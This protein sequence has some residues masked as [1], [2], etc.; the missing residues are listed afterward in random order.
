MRL[1]KEKSSPVLTLLLLI[2]LIFVV[3]VVLP[4]YVNLHRRAKQMSTKSRLDALHRALEY[5]YAAHGDIYPA[6]L[7]DLAPHYVSEIP[8]VELG[9]MKYNETNETTDEMEDSGKW[10]YHRY[11]G[12]VIVDSFSKDCDGKIISTW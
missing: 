6:M 5:Y 3:G 12:E 10:Y 4:G 1:K 7:E 11:S 8:M 9:L 2:V